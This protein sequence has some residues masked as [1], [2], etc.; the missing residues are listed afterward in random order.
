MRR[1]SLLLLS[2]F[3]KQLTYR[4]AKPCR[5]F[6]PGSICPSGDACTLYVAFPHAERKISYSLNCSI[7]A[8]PEK[9]LESPSPAPS[10]VKLQH[11]L[12]IEPVSAKEENTRKGYFPISWRVIGGGVTLGGAKGLFLIFL[13]SFVIPYMFRT[14]RP[15]RRRRIGPLG[16]FVASALP[17]VLCG[18]LPLD[19]R[20][21]RR[22]RRESGRQPPD[23]PPARVVHPIH[24][25][26]RPRRHLPRTSVSYF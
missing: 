11:E 8:D 13:F 19:R 14:H 25:H 12:P 5:Y 4:A 10:P 16:G 9:R 24:A 17:P 15:I 2:S 1:P 21:G 7:H 23:S 20:R 26:D 6:K 18:R 22:G 3:N